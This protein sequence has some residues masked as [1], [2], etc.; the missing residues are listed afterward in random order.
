MPGLIE[1]SNDKVKLVREKAIEELEI[2]DPAEAK[3]AK[4]KEVAK[5]KP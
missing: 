1:A 4:E 2:L 3:K 5:K